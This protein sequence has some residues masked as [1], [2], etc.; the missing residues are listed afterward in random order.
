MDYHA[1]LMKECNAETKSKD[2]SYLS[3]MQ[4]RSCVAHP[5]LGQTD[6]ERQRLRERARER[7]RVRERVRVRERER[8]REREMR[9]KAG[10]QMRMQTDLHPACIQ[11]H[12]QAHRLWH[13]D[14]GG[15]LLRSEGTRPRG[16]SPCHPPPRLPRHVL[17]SDPT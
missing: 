4:V 14:A 13:A 15:R 1:K 11:T 9:F 3:A 6:R 2:Q 5:Q 10:V 17:G 7:E 8:E 12:T 16:H